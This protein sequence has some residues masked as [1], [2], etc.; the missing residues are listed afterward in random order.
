MDEATYAGRTPGLTERRWTFRYHVGG[1]QPVGFALK[2]GTTL[3]RSVES[4]EVEAISPAMVLDLVQAKK[5]G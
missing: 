4:E 2:G 1:Q 5:T 3:C